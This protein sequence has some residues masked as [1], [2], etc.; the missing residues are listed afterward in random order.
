MKMNNNIKYCIILAISILV[1]C[2][3][4]DNCE[5]NPSLGN[6]GS[7]INSGGDDYLPVF[8]KNRLYFTSI[9]SEKGAKKEANYYSR[10]R[11]NGDFEAPELDLETPL[12]FVENSGSAAF[13]YDSLN[14]KTEVYFAGAANSSV[15]HKDIYLSEKTSEGWTTP[16]PLKANI[17]TKYYESHPA[18]SVDGKILVFS[19]DRPGSIGETDLYVSI[20]QEN[21]RWSNPENLGPEI[22]TPE[23]EISPFISRDGSLFFASK[24]Y[25]A[26]SGFD[27][28]KAEKIG[29]GKWAKAKTLAPPINSDKDDTGPALI[30]GKLALS[31]NR[32]GGCGGFDIYVFDLCGAALISGK[33]LG[34]NTDN[35]PCQ[36]K[37]FNS[38]NEL[39][40]DKELNI[41]E[42]YSFPVAPNNKYR[43]LFHNDCSAIDKQYDFNVPC[44]DSGVVKIVADYKVDFS[45]QEFEY[46]NINIPFFVSGYYYP[47]TSDNLSALKLKFDY[48]IFG[49]ADSTKYIENPGDSYDKYSDEVEKA[50]SDCVEKIISRVKYAKSKCAPS[51]SKVLIKVTGFT[52][53]RPISN[54]AKYSDSPIDDEIIGV[55]IEKGSCIDNDLLSKLRAYFTMKQLITLL[56]NENEYSEIK[57]YL[58][59]SIEGSGIDMNKDTNNN[60]KRKVC[61]NISISK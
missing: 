27:I 21:G 58:S 8:F 24:G 34:E 39:I 60:E 14:D 51:D 44:S 56:E 29:E 6:A 4:A 49:T 16:T 15:K 41:G 57:N 43:I 61:I 23:K 48:R 46:S 32:D 20:R 3:S 22:N 42:E 31:S 26:K 28:L 18:I 5:K 40:N 19:S 47:N 45:S 33:I 1:G 38:D 50:L 17:N 25:S 30:N 37:L 53:P 13:Y 35:S 52:D 59:W 36:V 2:K 9:R 54:V 55:K 12:K 10:I 11:A 7:V